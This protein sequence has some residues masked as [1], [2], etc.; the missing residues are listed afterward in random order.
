MNTKIDVMSRIAQ[1]MKQ[2]ADNEAFPTDERQHWLEVCCQPEFVEQMLVQV[3]KHYHSDDA[4]M[5]KLLDIVDSHL[6]KE[7]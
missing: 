2:L 5:C 1:F 7:F 3:A 6:I 4:G